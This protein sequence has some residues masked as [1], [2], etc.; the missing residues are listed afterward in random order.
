MQMKKGTILRWKRFNLDGPDKSQYY[1]HDIR[2]ETMSA[3]QRQMRGGSVMIWAGI[4]YFGKTSIKFINER[5]NSVPYIN[6]IKEQINNHAELDLIKSFNKIMHLYTHQDW[7]NH[8]LM[9]I[10]YLFC[11]GLHAPQTLILLKIAGQKLFTAYTRMES[12]INTCKN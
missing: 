2:K 4:S 11:R 12:S 5:M 9:K 3:I 6:L 8:I 7:S 1:F 10:I